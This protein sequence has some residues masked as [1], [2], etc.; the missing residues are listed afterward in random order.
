MK[1]RLFVIPI[2]LLFITSCSNNKDLKNDL[3]K[4]DLDEFYNT[5]PI[6]TDISSI[7]FVTNENHSEKVSKIYDTYE[8]LK[9][10]LKLEF[11]NSPYFDDINYD[12]IYSTDGFNSTINVFFKDTNPYYYGVES[13]SRDGILHLIISWIDNPAQDPYSVA[14]LGG[15]ELIETYNIVDTTVSI[16]KETRGDKVFYSSIFKY[17]DMT[18]FIKDEK[19]LEKLKEITESFP[20]NKIIPSVSC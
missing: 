20:V 17:N 1:K 14:I 15:S 9:N 10:D 8:E 2:I 6:S 7:S 16:I 19:D 5:K 18:Y 13:L 4:V 12:Y 11:L 3:M